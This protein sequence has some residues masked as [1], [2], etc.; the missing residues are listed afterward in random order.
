MLFVFVVFIPF[1][2]SFLFSPHLSFGCVSNFSPPRSSPVLDFCTHAHLLFEVPQCFWLTYIPHFTHC[3]ALNLA[4][5]WVGI[6]EV[7]GYLL[8]KCL[9]QWVNRL[10]VPS[11]DMVVKL[12]LKDFYSLSINRQLVSGKYTSAK[13]HICLRFPLIFLDCI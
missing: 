13:I 5:T 11:E 6:L 2:F 12:L 1:I 3:F 7:F 8:K 10:R 4:R 9:I